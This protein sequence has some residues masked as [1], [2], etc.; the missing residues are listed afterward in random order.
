MATV[1]GTTQPDAAVEMHGISWNTY[2]NLTRDL[3]DSSVPRLFYDRGVLEIL[4]PSRERSQYNRNLAF[5]VAIVADELGIEL[6]DRGSTTYSRQD[7]LRGFEPDS[8]FYI[9]NADQ[10]DGKRTLDLAIDP[11]PDL[12][13]EVDITSSSVDKESVYAA[14]GIPEVWRCS[15]GKVAILIL[16]PLIGTYRR[17]DSSRALPILS[18]VAISDLLEQSMSLK[19]TAWL[20]KIKDWVGNARLRGEL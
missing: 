3:E 10:I 4:S 8:S 7:L 18:D 19:R 11:P 15:N 20:K 13:I 9:R 1:A 12:I 2:E 6:L 14:I 5:F 16:D 17:A